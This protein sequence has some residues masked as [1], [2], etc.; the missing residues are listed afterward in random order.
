MTDEELAHFEAALGHHFRRPE[1]LEQ[2][3]THRS[4]RQ[5]EAELP[6]E[7]NDRLEF[8]GDRVLGLVVSEYLLKTFPDWDAG[9]LSKA[10][11]RL[12]SGASVRQA[13]ETVGIGQRLR[14]GRGE[15]LTGGREKQSLLADAY[16]AI[17]AAVYLDAGIG[18]AAAFIHRSL[19]EPAMIRAQ[20]PLHLSDHKSALQEWVQQHARGRVEYRIRR[21]SGP[22][23]QKLF[24]VEAWLDGNRL[25]ASEG[26]SKK[27]AEQAAARQALESLETAQRETASR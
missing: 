7:D 10:Q 17:V 19:L 15:E 3:L 12:V 16:E 6:A 18:A 5:R 23:H 22:D 13:A 2:A 25:A 1:W 9:K 4:A 20:G 14:I 27:E 24:E 26:R 8:F 11:S 21:E